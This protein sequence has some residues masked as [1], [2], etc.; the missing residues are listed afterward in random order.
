MLQ[1]IRSFSYAAEGEG[2]QAILGI[3]RVQRYTAR[4]LSIQRLFLH[5]AYINKFRDLFIK[6]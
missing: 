2:A 3:Q 4:I 6:L 1:I 5:S